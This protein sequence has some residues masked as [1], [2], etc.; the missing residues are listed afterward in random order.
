MD[1]ELSTG[2]NWTEQ[3]H[4]IMHVPSSPL[5]RAIK[6]EKCIWHQ[7]TILYSTPIAPPVIA[8]YR[9]GRYLSN[10][11]PN[12]PSS[13]CRHKGYSCNEMGDGPPS[14]PSMKRKQKTKTRGSSRPNAVPSPTPDSGSVTSRQRSDIRSFFIPA[15]LPTLSNPAPSH[16]PAPPEMTSD[17][18]N[19]HIPAVDVIQSPGS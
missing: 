18:P 8:A 15:P 3:G 11:W 17:M 5:F 13:L 10:R 1:P 2:G 6:L 14:K 7:N 4:C 12:H 16:H 9:S 19:T